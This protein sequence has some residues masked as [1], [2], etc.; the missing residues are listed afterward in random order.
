MRGCI[1]RYFPPAHRSSA[2]VI[3]RSTFLFESRSVSYYTEALYGEL[4]GGAHRIRYFPRLAPGD[5]A[6]RRARGLAQRGLLRR[7]G[8]ESTLLYGLPY[9]SSYKSPFK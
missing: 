4:Y 6:L 3:T 8:K 1:I 7:A 5:G 2:V 9:N